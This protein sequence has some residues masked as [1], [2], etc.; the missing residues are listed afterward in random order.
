MQIAGNFPTISAQKA[1]QNLGVAAKAGDTYTGQHFMPLGAMNVPSSDIRN[2]VSGGSWQAGSALKSQGWPE[3]S[4]FMHLLAATHDNTANNFS[5]QIAAHFYDN[6]K[7]WWRSTGNSGTTEWNQLLHTGNAPFVTLEMFGGKADFIGDTVNCHDNKAALDQA[8]ATGKSIWLGSGNYYVGSNLVVV[9]DVDE[10]IQGGGPA[11]SAIVFGPAC[12]EGLKS[13]KTSDLYQTM[14]RNFSI[15][16]F[17][18]EKVIGIDAQNAW[19][20][21]SHNHERGYFE[22]LHIIGWNGT[23]HGP[24]GGIK[25]VDALWSNC[26]KI[27]IAGRRD[28]NRDSASVVSAAYT[29]CEFGIF[30]DTA[31]ASGFGYMNQIRVYGCKIA[32][33]ARA[34]NGSIEGV[35]L[36]QFDF[37]DVLWGV[38]CENKP[39]SYGAGVVV[40]TGHINGFYGGISLKYAPQAQISN[41]LCYK[42]PAGETNLQFDALVCDHSDTCQTQ[43]LQLINYSPDVRPLCTLVRFIN[44]KGCKVSGTVLQSDVVAVFHQSTQ[45]TVK[46]LIPNNP[47]GKMIVADGDSANKNKV[48]RESFTV[49]GTNADAVVTN[50]AGPIV[51]SATV[52]M[53]EGETRTCRIYC[54][55]FSGAAGAELLVIAVFVGG[56]GL[57]TAYGRY[58]RDFRA[59]ATG[60]LQAVH[61]E[62][63]FLCTQTGSVT[64]GAQVL[65]TGGTGTVPAGDCVI[66][67]LGES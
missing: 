35:S 62:V 14:Y 54:S 30:Y 60:S 33:H 3:D 29:P 36:T 32:V 31:V 6:R 18:A 4:A 20:Y 47:A 38:V 63:P 24:L 9:G 15:K 43:G 59:P 61:F 2:R 48:I 37:V 57:A 49:S 40:E 58:Q 44:S 41:V 7:L 53:R 5:L 16:V 67:V 65:L 12:T 10:D 39:G 42:I 8:R 25:L 28:A 27:Y 26:N 17:S 64:I 34:L 11:M 56:S 55:H 22:S 13:Y 50:A 19:D 52:D 51:A 46:V 66:E 21:H 23:I 1:R 45:N